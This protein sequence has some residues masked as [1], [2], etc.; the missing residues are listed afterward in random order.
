M[1]VLLSTLALTVRLDIALCY[2]AYF[3]ILYFR[4]SF[5]IYN[6]SKTVGVLLIVLC[7]LLALHYLVLGYFINPTGRTVVK[8]IATRLD[9]GFSLIFRYVT[10]NAFQWSL[11]ANALIVFLALV[12]F[13]HI[14]PTSKSGFLLF[15]WIAPWRIFLPFRVMPLG[16]IAAPTIPM[17]SFAAV[18]YFSYLFSKRKKIGLVLLLIVTQITAVA[19]YYPLIKIFPFKIEVDGRILSTFPLGFPPVDYHYRQRAIYGREKIAKVVAKE[20]DHDV[21]IIGSGREL[22]VYE[23]YLHQFRNIT[24]HNR[25]IID[26][27][28]FKRYITPEN[29]FLIFDFNYNWQIKD[30]VHR[31]I[32]E[33]NIAVDKIHLMPYWKKYPLEIETFFLNKESIE[34]ILYWETKNKNQE[35]KRIRY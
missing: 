34:K 25:L 32:K 23:Y 31:I 29:V 12:G 10:I 21:V 18:L 19:I 20:K 2:G 28:I 26:D 35:G 14:G 8:H 3:G 6:F 5:S 4:R 7:A 22:T 30:P 16:R 24:S 33:S 11:S 27:I 13:F 17:L 1:F 9:S 15:S